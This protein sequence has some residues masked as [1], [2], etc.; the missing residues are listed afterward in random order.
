VEQARRS[1]AGVLAAAATA[2]LFGILLSWSRVGAQI[3]A[4]AYDTLLQFFPPPER[5][6][7]AVILAIDE[8]SLAA[9]GGILRM[10]EPLAEALQIAA[11][12][13]PAAIA[14]DLVLSEPRGEAVD[15][16]LAQSFAAIPN[17]VL[18][19]S[20]RADAEVGDGEWEQ[21]LPIFAEQAAALG[22]VH[23]EPDDD[24]ICRRI[25]LGKVAGRDRRWA[26]ALETYR[27]ASGNGS[28]TLDEE[29]LSL[30]S[31]EGGQAI[32][33]PA[34]RR[35]DREMRIR[36]P[37]PLSPIERISLRQVIEDPAQA[38][39]IRGR[40]VFVGVYVLGGLDQYLMTPLSYGRAMSGVE[41]NASAYETLAAREYLRDLSES[42]A[43]AI[44]L[45]LSLALAAGFILLEGRP[46]LFT[47]GALLLGAH[48]IPPAI[49][50]TGRVISASL[51]L[52][53]GWSCFLALAAL[54]Y[55]TMRR[56]MVG[57]EQSS[58][59]YQRAVHYV[60]HEMRT[61]LTAIQGSS[62]LISRYELPEQ[63]RKEIAEL[64][65]SESERL[66]RMVEMFLSVERLRSGQLD[67]RREDVDADEAVAA[68]IERNRPLA[69]RKHI[70]I[71]HD[72]NGG[73]SIWADREFL[74]Y[75]CYNL[76]SNAVKYSP[77]QTAVTV[78]VRRADSGVLILVEDQGYGMD[79]DDLKNVFKRFYR[80]RR[81][82]A[83][84]ESGSGLGLALVEEIVLQHGGTIE[85]ESRVG[86]GSRF[87]VKLPRVEQTA[88]A[89]GRN[90]AERA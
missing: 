40:A 70:E 86:H 10:R 65:H 26:L 83:S 84:G 61:P 53:V 24:G 78:R 71:D 12:N 45:L 7:A 3:D 16:L 67:L 58:E 79:E 25:L 89:D 50:V 32:F 14:V 54:Q 59:R 43:F 20:L 1:T 72:R 76:I 47:A 34:A 44:A 15:R 51:P 55:L 37:N 85:V 9:Y 27:L 11:E 77:A 30:E 6:S 87:T 38:E 35:R 88:A 33:I 90:D 82:Q 64:I 80:A 41:I 36:Y 52:L 69:E 18:A 46:A 49:F 23:A 13:E 56:R 29:G 8:D 63:K 4:R 22:H 73:S 17:L 74:E 68:A 57:A 31:G 75:A 28:L 66:G 62:E 60:T 21:P 42:S 81:A 19:T 5:S 39:I 2:T 48:L